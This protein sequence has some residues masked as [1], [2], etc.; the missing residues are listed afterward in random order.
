VKAQAIPDVEESER[1]VAGGKVDLASLEVH[2]R[3]PRRRDP[4]LCDPASRF[5][6]RSLDHGLPTRGGHLPAEEDFL[7]AK[8]Y[9]S[10]IVTTGQLAEGFEPSSLFSQGEAVYINFDIDVFDPAF[11]PGTGF[12]E[13]GGLSYREIRPA[14]AMLARRCR[15]VGM[16]VVEVNPY[17]DTAK[18]T[19]LLAARLILDTLSF[20]FG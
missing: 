14:L 20:V 11:A 17:L 13:P 18:M 4:L 16:D 9:G 3:P 8:R 15:I 10:Q 7:A 5:S 2:H 6:K 1:K 19:A 12:P